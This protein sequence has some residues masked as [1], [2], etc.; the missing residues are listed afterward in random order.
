MNGIPTTFRWEREQNC[1]SVEDTRQAYLVMTLDL[2]ND[3]QIWFSCCRCSTKLQE[4][5]GGI[6][7]GFYGESVRPMVSLS[8]WRR[9]DLSG[10]A[11]SRM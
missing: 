8:Q 2:Q 5:V 1:R 11:A 3:I 4:C 7:M 10:V 6:S 9:D